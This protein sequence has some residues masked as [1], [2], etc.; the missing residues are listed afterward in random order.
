MAFEIGEVF[1]YAILGFFLGAWYF[2]KGFRKFRHKRVIENIETSKIRSV[3]IGP[4]EIV[5]KTRPFG[6]LLKSPITKKDCVFYS[7]LVEEYRGSGKSSRWVTIY[8]HVS[9]EPFYVQDQ[10]GKV[11]VDP[12]GANVVSSSYIFE[13]G[14]GKTVPENVNKFFEE[15]DL[16]LKGLVFNKRI[17]VRE[18]T[19]SNEQQVYVLG[20]AM[21]NPHF[22]N[23]TFKTDEK[24]VMI[25]KGNMGDD[26][27]ISD[28]SEKELLSS[29]VSTSNLY[30]YG[31]AALMAGCLYV[32]LLIL[33]VR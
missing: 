32:I 21:D 14:I 18:C 27:T 19:I 10:T 26:F 11:L 5:G 23:G 4:A 29:V 28:K 24:D 6:S 8:K 7:L 3:A 2:F 12:T 25:A 16:K 30:I 9:T 15:N 1:I 17:R 33:G 31:G 13:S 20:E 22:E